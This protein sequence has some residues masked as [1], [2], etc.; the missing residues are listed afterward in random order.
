MW[1]KNV[2]AKIQYNEK[3]FAHILKSEEP[4]TWD[5]R[6][7]NLKWFI[8]F[9]QFPPL[10]Q[11]KYYDKWQSMQLPYGDLII[12]FS[13]QKKIGEIFDFFQP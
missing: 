13:L 3:F 9:S 4:Y 1:K 6:N 5:T 8:K 2:T 11:I 10:S 7:L 12:Y